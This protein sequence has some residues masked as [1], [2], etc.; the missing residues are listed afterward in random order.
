MWKKF[1]EYLKKKRR[2]IL[3]LDYV[4]N[5]NTGEVHNLNNIKSRCKLHLISEKNKVYISKKKFDKSLTGTISGVSI[6]GCRYCNS[7]TDSDKRFK[8]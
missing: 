5:K 3:K 7:T 1:F 8:K 2:E 6:N 4:L